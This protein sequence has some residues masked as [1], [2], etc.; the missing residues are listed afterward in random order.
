MESVIGTL[1]AY[2]GVAVAVA[3]ACAAVTAG[4]AAFCAIRGKRE[5]RRW[6]ERWPR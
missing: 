5:S 4:Y 1:S 6:D 3:A 2:A